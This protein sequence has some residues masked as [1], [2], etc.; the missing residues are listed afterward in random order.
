M[1]V[2]NQEFDIIQLQY[3]TTERLLARFELVDD[4]PGYFD[5]RMDELKETL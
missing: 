4:L 3:K 2:V 1:K 5:Q